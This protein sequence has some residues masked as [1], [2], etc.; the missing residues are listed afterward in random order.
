MVSEQANTSLSIAMPAPDSAA[1][2]PIIP[3]FPTHSDALSS[4]KKRGS[5]IFSSPSL[6]SAFLLDWTLSLLNY[7]NFSKFEFLTSH[8]EFHTGIDTLPKIQ[9]DN[10]NDFL[11]DGDTID[12]YEVTLFL[13]RHS[14]TLES[15]SLSLSRY[16]FTTSW[17]PA[18]RWCSSFSD[19]PSSLYLDFPLLRHLAFTSYHI[20]WFLD[21]IMSNPKATQFLPNLSSLT[22]RLFPDRPEAPNLDQVLESIL[23]L[24]N[25][26][27]PGHRCADWLSY[28]RLNAKG[29]PAVRLSTR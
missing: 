26:E 23:S 14:G 11:F 19:H 17:I 7:G 18:G 4:P 9:M 12:P 2:Y 10:L 3:V 21:G 5:I 24:V 15:I 27:N 6:F 1:V 25:L 22:I 29:V 20:P 13:Q 16:F 8:F 28:L